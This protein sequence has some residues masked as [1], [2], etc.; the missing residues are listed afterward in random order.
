MRKLGTLIIVWLLSMGFAF[1]QTK[2]DALKLWE[3]REDAQSLQKALDI[4]E[5]LYKQK[6]D[7]IESLEYLSRGYFL[8]A[9]GHIEK[10]ADKKA[11][12]EKAKEF[13]IRGLETN[14]RFAEVMKKENDM[15]KAVEVLTKR[16][17]PCLQWAAASLGKW[18]K[19]NGIFSSLGYKS[20]IIAMVKRVETLSP[21]FFYGAVP[22][23]W[24]G[25]Y[26]VAPSIAGGDMDKSKKYFEEAIAKAPDYL[27]TRVLFA[28]LYWVKKG[29]KE[30]FKKQLNSVIAATKNPIEIAPENNIEKKKAQKL[31]SKIDELF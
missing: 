17:V 19:L 15:V 21:D 2:A 24:G 5:G 1:A 4:F 29:D 28:E 22:R 20:T 9:D 6:A 25:F 11:A 14:A 13:G 8:M 16:E 27:A 10:D 23:Y 3:K 7:D 31:L 18:A 26:A 12:F 30:E